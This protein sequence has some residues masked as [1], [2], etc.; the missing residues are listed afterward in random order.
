M[1]HGVQQI[2]TSLRVGGLHDI[3][4]RTLGHQLAAALAGAGADV[5]D[6]L[7][8][9]N[10]VL[11]VL[12]HDQ[13]VALV[14]QALQRTEQNLVVARVQPDGR[15]VQHVTHTLQVAAEL[16]REPDALRLATAQRW[17]AAVERQ[18]AKAHLLQKFEPALDLGNQ[19]AR[20]V[21]F[22]LTH[23]AN[24]LQGLH[25]QSDV[26]HAQ[27]RDVGDRHAHEPDSARRRVETG[28]VAGR[29]GGI[30]QVFHVGLGKRLLTPASVLTTHRIVEHLAL[31]LGQL[32]AGADT[33][34]APAVLAVVGEQTR[35]EF[36]I[37]G[38]AQ[39]AGALGGERVKLADLRGRR[40]VLHRLAQAG[41]TAQHMQHALAVHQRR[42]QRFAQ[43]RL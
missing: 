37:T 26:G 33:V 34:R 31:V 36:G 2:A 42:R 3:G 11:V 43:L 28:P 13:R 7:C 29:A 4:D 5:D 32:D 22:A 15:L 9:A 19:I 38:T 16:R 14:T 1:L 20:N 25:P 24:C 21:A 8:V 23:A 6:V 27:A 12:D 18:V 30:D 40:A 35:V 41:Q 39:R 10:R 17:R